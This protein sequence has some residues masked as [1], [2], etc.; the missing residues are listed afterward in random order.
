MG[1][2]K[3]IPIS[4][5]EKF[6]DQYAMKLMGRWD[7]NGFAKN[8]P[9]LLRTITKCMYGYSEREIERYKTRLNAENAK[10]EKDIKD[11]SD[12]KPP[13]REKG[14]ARRPK[15]N[16][17]PYCQRFISKSLNYKTLIIESEMILE[18][19][20]KIPFHQVRSPKHTFKPHRNIRRH[21]CTK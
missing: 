7:Y 6:F 21:R 20:G 1:G 9:T 12:T 13:V 8:Y 17:I 4:D 16:M 2:E 19:G 14:F 18:S 5:E 10:K 11:T 15:A 3:I